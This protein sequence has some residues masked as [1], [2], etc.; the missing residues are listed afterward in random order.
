MIGSQGQV[1]RGGTG[2]EWGL[3]S[4]SEA[5]GREARGEARREMIESQTKADA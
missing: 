4:S 1:S 5:G 3:D 2:S